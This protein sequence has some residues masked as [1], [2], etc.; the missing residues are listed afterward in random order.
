MKRG[1][2]HSITIVSTYD[3]AWDALDKLLEDCF[4]SEVEQ[5]TE[6]RYF[7]FRSVQQFAETLSLPLTD[8]GQRLIDIVGQTPVENEPCV[9]IMSVHRSKGLEWPV[10]ILS[11]V[12][13]GGFPPCAQG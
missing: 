9:L 8:F 2:D 12:F 3:E 4:S 10:V 5:D 6:D 7:M 11:D 13:Q 1:A